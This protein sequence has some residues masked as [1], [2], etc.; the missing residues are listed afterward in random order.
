MPN[1]ILRSAALLSVLVASVA[2]FSR[3]ARAQVGPMDPDQMLQQGAAQAPNMSKPEAT[4]PPAVPGAASHAD[5]VAPATQI[6][7]D[8]SPNAALFDAINRGD[9]AAAR[10]ALSRGAELEARNVLGLTP[11]ELSVDLGRNDISFLLLSYRGSDSGPGAPTRANAAP[12]AS[13]PETTA[14]SVRRRPVIQ[15]KAVVP[16]APRTPR[17]FAN[18]GGTPVVGAGFLGFGAGASAR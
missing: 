10:D 8:M 4:P 14:K 12:L 9:I 5:S 1:R 3:V 15:A 18:D 16:A 17:L 7:T 6:P 13:P 2:G 11:M